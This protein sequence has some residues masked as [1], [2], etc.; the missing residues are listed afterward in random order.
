LRKSEAYCRFL[1]A[2]SRPNSTD[3]HD[4]ASVTPAWTGGIQ[5]R[6]DASGDIPVNLG[7]GT[8]CRNDDI[9]EHSPKSSQL[10]VANS[11]TP[12]PSHDL[13]RYDKRVGLCF[14]IVMQITFLQGLGC[15]KEMSL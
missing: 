4:I 3:D 9:E 15:L 8:P 13:A 12:K 6:K 10:R 1:L 11:R 7:S 2:N 14:R 5:V